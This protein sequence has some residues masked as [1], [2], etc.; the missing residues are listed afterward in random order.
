MAWSC[1]SIQPRQPSPSAHHPKSNTGIDTQSTSRS[2]PDGNT[3]PAHH[4][5]APTTLGHQVP[6]TLPRLPVVVLQPRALPALQE[7]LT[8]AR[9][10][11]ERVLWLHGQRVLV[12]AQRRGE[13]GA[14]VLHEAG[15]SGAAGAGEAVQGYGV[16]VGGDLDG[17]AGGC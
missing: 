2:S 16:D 14:A 15:V 9:P 11:P 6:R 17:D 12:A 10:E 1:S 8:R 3:H 13:E 5:Q 4:F 7:P